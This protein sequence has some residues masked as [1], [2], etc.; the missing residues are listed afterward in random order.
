MEGST[1]TEHISPETPEISVQQQPRS[2]E[3][4]W[5]DLEAQKR[6][7]EAQRLS[8]QECAREI[9]AVL[10]KIMSVSDTLD[11]ARREFN[12]MQD[13]MI[14]MLKVFC[15]IM[16]FALYQYSNIISQYEGMVVS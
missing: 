15:F 6:D 3:E 7:L 5:K 12:N 8:L 1:A 2:L 13:R 4:E 11:N 14:F 10:E 16:L 9:R